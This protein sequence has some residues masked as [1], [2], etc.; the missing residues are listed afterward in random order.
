[1]LDVEKAINPKYLKPQELRHI[2]REVDPRTIMHST[3]F[4]GKP[5][6]THKALR[7]G[8]NGETWRRLV[9]EAVGYS[10]VFLYMRLLEDS[11]IWEK[12]ASNARCKIC[13]RGTGADMLLLCDQCDEGYHMECLSPPLAEVPDGDWFCPKCDP[14]SFATPKGKKKRKK[15][16]ESP[17]ADE[18]GDVKVPEAKRGRKQSKSG[19][20]PPKRSSA[21]TS[22]KAIKRAFASDDDGEE[23]DRGANGASDRSSRPGSRRSGRSS[24]AGERDGST[25]LLLAEEIVETLRKHDCGRWFAEPVRKRDAPDYYDVVKQPMDFAQLRVNLK[26]G[27][28]SHIAEFVSDLALIFDNA[29]L[30]NGEKSPIA[31]DASEL[32][33]FYEDTFQSRL[34]HYAEPAPTRSKRKRSI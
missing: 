11:V 25:G 2:P 13:R 3:F 7:V 17:T 9:S 20:R 1:M 29:V 24:D 8:L 19:A 23:A 4:V 31:R 32:S 33:M 30:Y 18:V 14:E 10:Q 6:S 27:D 15:T 5:T 26:R 34:A 21:V 16:A 28:Y 12:S 22:R